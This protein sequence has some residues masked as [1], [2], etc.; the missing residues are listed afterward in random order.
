ML[1]LEELVKNRTPYLFF[2]LYT[3][4]GDR[5]RMFHRIS[6][7]YIRTQLL[8]E[9][10]PKTKSRNPLKKYH[11][12]IDFREESILSKLILLEDDDWKNRVQEIIGH[13]PKRVY[14]PFNLENSWGAIRSLGFWFLG[15]PGLIG[16]WES[17][18]ENGRKYQKKQDRVQIYSPAF[19]SHL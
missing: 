5:W 19:H 3:Y 16:C 9:N 13:I 4:I 17:E 12:K 8:E 2:L 18:W 1:T 14:I 6:I 15:V 10:Y 11:T 7:A